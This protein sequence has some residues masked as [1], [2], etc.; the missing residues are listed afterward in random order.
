MNKIINGGSAT[1]VY[2]HAIF[3]SMALLKVSAI[4]KKE[5][6]N[7]LLRNIHFIQEPLQKIA[8]AGATGSGKTT[9]LKIIAGLIQPDSG[10]VEFEGARVKGPNEKLLPGHPRIAYLSQHFELRNNYRVEEILQI[11]NK[12]SRK[13]EELVSEVCRIS[14]LLKRWSDELSGGERQR[15]ALARLLLTVPKLLLLDEPYSNLDAVHK[16]IL[17]KVIDDISEQLKTSCILVSHDSADTLSWSDEIIV[18]ENGKII[19]RGAPENVYKEPVNAYAASLFGTYNLLSEDLLQ[20][21][22]YSGNQRFFRPENFKIDSM[23]GVKAKVKQARFMGSYY[24]TEVEIGTS[25]LLLHSREALDKDDE[26]YV[27]LSN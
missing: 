3:G 11:A 6:E 18:L 13:D 16:S 25:T 23:H 14:H 17:K 24:E 8:I 2:L 26:V 19:Q 10:E 15:I 4:S 5:G 12:G 21:F 20:Q 27:S 22:M 1:A 9:L 7:F